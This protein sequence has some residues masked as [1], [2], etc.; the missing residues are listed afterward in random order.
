MK[1]VITKFIAQSV[2]ATNMITQ[3]KDYQGKIQ[4]DQNKN[5]FTHVLIPGLTLNHTLTK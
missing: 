3:N 5:H 1:N 2:K 4:L